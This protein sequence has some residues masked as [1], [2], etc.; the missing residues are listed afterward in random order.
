MWTKVLS[1][2]SVSSCFAVR[3][4]PHKCTTSPKVRCGLLFW[5]SKIALESLPVVILS[6]IVM[7]AI[8]IS[9]GKT[10]V[11]WLGKVVFFLSTILQHFDTTACSV[12]SARLYREE[13]IQGR[14]RQQKPHVPY[15]KRFLRNIRGSILNLLSFQI[16]AVYAYITIWFHISGTL[17]MV[18]LMGGS[19]LLKVIMQEAAK[20]LIFNQQMHSIEIMAAIVGIPTIL[21]H[22]HISIL[23]LRSHNLNTTISGMLSS[24]AIE[25]AMRAGKA[26]LIKRQIRYEAQRRMSILT[27]K[28]DANPNC[29]TLD[30][31]N[32]PWE[33]A[34]GQVEHDS[35]FATWKMRLLHYYAAEVYV[36]MFAEY[37]A[38]GCSYVI[39]VLFWNH[40]M[41]RLGYESNDDN[42]THVLSTSLFKSSRISALILQVGIE[43]VGDCVACTLEAMQGI[44][45][46]PLHAHNMYLTFFLVWAAVANATIASHV[47]L[48]S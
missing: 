27:E 33:G 5:W 16:A 13:T 4:Q 11:F 43:I 38:L 44:D 40:P 46:R 48:R 29:N 10:S 25:I 45:M 41:Y 21:I 20:H 6:T 8:V 12:A 22:T 37:V 28:E 30:V 42:A 17:G 18:A 36:D 2:L 9:S 24:A 39:L 19:I 35:E 34:Q 3:L 7:F 32:R 15:I 23:M 26:L 47:F 1:W 14:S 31:L